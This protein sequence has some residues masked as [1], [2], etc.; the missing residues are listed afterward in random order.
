[1][2][3]SSPPL[4]SCER[5]RAWLDAGAPGAAPHGPARWAI[6]FVEARRA[7]GQ[8]AHFAMR[9]RRGDKGQWLITI[10]A[11][12]DGNRFECYRGKVQEQLPPDVLG[13]PE[14]PAH[15]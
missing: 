12:G 11:R 9:W 14:V 2:E 5:I 6:K 7:R 15:G 8:D 10:G 1:M 4:A 3:I 13:T